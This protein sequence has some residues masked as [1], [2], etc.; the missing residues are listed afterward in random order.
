MD[1][2]PEFDSKIYL[3]Q[4]IATIAFY[5]KILK[6]KLIKG[7]ASRN[8]PIYRGLKHYSLAE[9]FHNNIWINKKKNCQADKNVID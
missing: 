2:D 3:I 5:L 9:Q 4:K 1:F 7:S 8:E 6:K